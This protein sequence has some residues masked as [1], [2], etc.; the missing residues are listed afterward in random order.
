MGSLKHSF[1]GAI[2]LLSVTGLVFSAEQ[3]QAAATA[4]VAAPVATPAAAPASVEQ[5]VPADE[6]DWAVYM[7]A[8][9]YHFALVKEYLQKGDPAKAAAELKQA[10]EFL[11]F[12]KSRLAVASRQIEELANA[13]ASGKEK[14]LAKIEAVTSN[15]LKIIDQKYAMVPVEISGTPIFENA[16][17][18]HFEKAKSKLQGND[19]AGAAAE[20]KK[21]ISFLRLKAAHIGHQAKA[22]IDAAVNELKDAVAKIESGTM[23]GVKELDQVIQKALSVF[24]KKK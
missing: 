12:E 10:N 19:K 13:I 3:K 15:A 11:A 20:M 16:Y 6:A 21:A 8:P 9:A 1:I 17:K 2:A 7:E 5:W 23:K 14:D 22:D 4:P 18:Y 24:T